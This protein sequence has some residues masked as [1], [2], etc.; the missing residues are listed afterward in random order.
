MNRTI[1]ID[2]PAFLFFMALLFGG[3]LRF[4][5]AL[6]TR[7]PINDGG[8]FYDMAR[9]LQ[10]SHYS[11]P[12]IT[13]YNRLDLPYAYPPFGIYFA[14][15]LADVGRVPLLAV[16]LWLPPLLSLL[17]IP[18]FYRLARALLTDNL[19]ASVA[20]LFFA[21]TPGR[22]DWH[23]MGGGVTRAFGVLFLLLAVFYVLRL[24]Q[25]GKPGLIFLA[26]VFC[27]LA[28]LSHPEVGLQTAGLCAVL[29]LCLGRTRRGTIHAALV[30]LGVILLTAPWWGRV[31]A[32]H[33]L[34]PFLSAVQ[35]GQ[36]ASVAWLSL[37]QGIFYSGEF[38]PLL[39]ILYVAGLAYALWKRQFIFSALIFVPALVDPRSAAFIAYLSLSML[40]SI[41]FLEALPALFGKLRGSQ[42]DSHL[43]N[44]PQMRLVVLFAIAFILFLECGLLN[45]RLI[46]TTL[47]PA[48][49][50]TLTWIQENLPPD[51]DFLLITGR[52]YSMSDPIQEW[53][54]TLTGQH[55]QTTLQG[56]E[57]TLGAGFT[58]RLND[59]AA[60]QV[61]ADLTCVDAWVAR[62][63]LKFDY[64]LMSKLPADDQSES[65]RTLHNLLA[66][67]ESTD[68]YRLIH[69]SASA[70]IFVRVDKE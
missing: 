38:L 52:Q 49:R 26:A 28:V 67:L 31:V 10:A 20:T 22:Y 13:S 53:F 37:L 2:W 39:L 21:L 36:H 65:A 14:S 34:T 1:K 63:G 25:E 47:T 15:L 24:F 7:F 60:L 8:M 18:A 61:C 70:A 5:P 55:S 6:T 46:N 69:E 30:A 45:F 42:S 4:M 41:G 11:L 68:R 27:G 29:W 19:R 40:A 33:G 58:S 57:W 54:P 56:L 43:A 32:A 66:E 44:I 35:T 3:L 9:D 17:A 50:D 62:T 64:L 48:D 16:F 12:T 23:I 59:L 51:R